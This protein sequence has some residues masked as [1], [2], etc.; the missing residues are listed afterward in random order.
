MGV[1]DISIGA[2]FIAGLLSFLSPC[3][4]PLVPA[5]LGFLGGVSIHQLADEPDAR[6]TRNGARRVAWAA[7]AF[8]LGFATV[9]VAL[10]ATAS[11]ISRLV[12]QHLDWLATI[13]GSILILFGVHTMGWLPVPLLY[14]EARFHLERKPAGLVGA[15]VI[16]LAFALGWTPCVGPILAAILTIAAAKESL[17]QGSALLAVY[18]AGIGVPFLAA[19]L[20]ARRF[21]SLMT[22]LRQHVVWVERVTGLLLIVTGI[23][24]LT[25]TISDASY[26][27]LETFPV[28]GTIG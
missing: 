28:L 10:G 26:W 6:A 24:I 3:V 11:T 13:A 17:T 21:L 4:L 23:A 14:R 22:R 27:L 18:A 20:A 19:A 12:T 2:A 15:Y 7:F 8:V 25:G 5:Y 9:F 16:G 1:F